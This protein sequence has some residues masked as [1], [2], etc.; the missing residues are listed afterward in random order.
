MLNRVPGLL[1]VA[2]MCAFPVAAAEDDREREEARRQQAFTDGMAAIVEDLNDGSFVSLVRAM[3]EEKVLERIFGL[4]LI[5]PR[6]KRDFR[7]R[8]QSDDGFGRF[9]QSLYAD[10][11]QDGLR[12]RLLTVESR[13][14]RGR[15]VVR[16]DMPHFQF[17]YIEYQLE[18]DDEGRLSVLDWDDYMRGYRMSDRV[19]LRLVQSQ[20]SVNSA[21]KLVDFSNVKERDVFRIIEVLKAARDRDVRRFL[22]I[23]ESLDDKL[24]RQRAVL[25]VGLDAARE[26]RKRRSQRQIL[27]AIDRFYPN[28][29]L[30]ALS[31]LDYYFPARK[32]ERAHEALVRLSQKLRVDD[33]V[34]NARLSSSSL[35]M[36]NLDDAVTFAEKSVE[37]EPE[38]ELGWWAVL[39]AQVAAANYEAAVRSLGQLTGRFGH[40]LGPDAL[41]K[42]PS[43]KGFSESDEYRDWHAANSGGDP[44]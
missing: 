22:E 5:D 21:R 2:I 12:A 41:G 32:Y 27:I 14:T 44:G 7:E 29:P 8:V 18:L 16:F 28:E 35:V 4:R 33:G 40:A 30:F 26:A 13:G 10:E 15:A 20:P 38:L 43:L 1:C 36:G 17:N 37:L 39:R 31:L 6:I 34:T 24:K 3:D 42:D 25:V 19:G 23:Y 9:V 11:A